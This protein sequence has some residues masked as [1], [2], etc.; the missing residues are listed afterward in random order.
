MVLSLGTMPLANSLVDPKK[1]HEAEPTYPLELLFCPECRLVQLSE[2]VDPAIIFDD[3]VYMTGTSSTMA[4]HYAALAEGHVARFGLGEESLVV[5]VGANDGSMLRAFAKKG[6]RTLGIEP[7]A[8][9]ARI[10]R[11]AGI[12]I[13]PRFFDVDGGS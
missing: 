5:D 10:A 6:V 2:I 11:D 3:Y 4:R 7:A 9:L 8:N 1:R 12:E 13:V